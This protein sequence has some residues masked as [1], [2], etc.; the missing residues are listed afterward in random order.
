MNTINKQDFS[1]SHS[2]T[3]KK[4]IG[5]KSRELDDVQSTSKT[6][7]SHPSYWKV[8][9]TIYKYVGIYNIILY[10]SIFI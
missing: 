1:N 9:I 5:V 4:T 10:I 3:Q 6:S 8:F 7:Y 2:S